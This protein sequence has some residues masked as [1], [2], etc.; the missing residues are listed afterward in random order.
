VRCIANDELEPVRDE[1]EAAA[2]GLIPCGDCRPL[3]PA[4]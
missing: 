1:R 3:V 2:L 4:A